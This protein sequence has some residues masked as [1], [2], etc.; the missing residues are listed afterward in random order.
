MK[1]AVIASIAISVSVMIAGAQQNNLNTLERL[2][3]GSQVQ[4]EPVKG[5]TKGG[6]RLYKEM[7]DL[8][9]V[10]RIIPAN[11]QIE[12]ISKQ[13]D[14]LQVKDGDS[15][16]YVEAAKITITQTTPPVQQQAVQ[17]QVVQQ[18]VVQQQ[19]DNRMTYLE[20][21]YGKSIAARIYAGK[22]W[23]GM[24][25]EMVKDAWGE[26]DRVNNV[27]VKSVQMQEMVYR[28]TWLLMEKGLLKEWGPVTK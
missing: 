10:I 11:T 8:T 2:E 5:I 6:V 14:Y 23:K 24:T 3:N 21:K 26:P 15:M 25:T 1:R 9:S 22:I 18:E 28:S 13:G 4:Q 16:G 12:I 19:P 20:T 27:V 17:Q 7:D